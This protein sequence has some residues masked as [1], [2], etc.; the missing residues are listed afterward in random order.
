MNATGSLPTQ[1]SAP[2]DATVHRPPLAVVSPFLDRSYGTERII[3]EWIA[4]LSGKFDIHIYSKEVKDVDLATVTWH[5]IPKLPGPHLFNFLW[6]F[7]AN[8][9]WRRWDRYVRGLDCELVL[10]PGINC[11]DADVIS[12]H[13]VFA[14]FFQRVREELQFSKNSARLWPRLLHRRLYY[15]LIIFL[16]RHIYTKGR[17]VLVLIAHKTARDLARIYSRSENCHV[18][19]LGLNHELYNPARRAALRENARQELSLSRG[20]FAVLMVGNDLHKKGIRVLLEAMAQLRL[21]PVDLLLA[22]REDPA[23]FRAMAAEHGL[24]DRVRF[25]PPRK[26]VEYYYAAADAYA[27]PSLEDTYALPPV[28]AMA[29]GLPTIVSSENGTCEIIVHGENGLIL[30]DPRDAAGLA[31]MIRKLCNDKLFCESLGE[32]AAQTAGQFTWERNADE[33]AGIFREILERKAKPG[34]RAELST[35]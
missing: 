11:L 31:A 14:E 28:E 34:Q 1:M 19:Y 7:I 15:A 25:L 30:D 9:L 20:R 17:N 3:V 22:G 21:D 32:K 13:I 4:R 33:L 5:R 23:P 8:H 35:P 29:C 24:Q 26:D 12:V 16:E 6:W 27:G 18:L 2:T 10:S